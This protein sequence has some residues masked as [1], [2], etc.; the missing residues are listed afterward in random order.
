MKP[1]RHATLWLSIGWGIVGLVVFFSLIP[2][3]PEPIGFGG[4]DKLLH[5]AAYTLAMFWFGLVYEPGRGLSSMA[6]SL[7]ALGIA[8]EVLQGLTPYRSFQYLDM[9][10]NALG[11]FLG[12]ILSATRLSSGLLLVEARLMSPSPDK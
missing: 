5:I 4:S 1:L 8:L 6:V 2:S 7:M 9:A 12:W 10:S 3:P 11:V